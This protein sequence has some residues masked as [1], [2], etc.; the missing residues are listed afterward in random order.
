[1]GKKHE[2]KK[3]VVP[4]NVLKCQDSHLKNNRNAVL[5]SLKLGIRA[6]TGG[7][8]GGVGEGMNQAV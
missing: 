1:M 6:K 4:P 8:G 3:H 5:G 2:K 7:G